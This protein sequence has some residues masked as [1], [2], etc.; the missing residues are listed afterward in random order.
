M[1]DRIGE[2]VDTQMPEG[3]NSWKVTNS[4]WSGQGGEWWEMWPLRKA[5]TRSH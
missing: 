2:K 5:G 1:G 3:R 4:W